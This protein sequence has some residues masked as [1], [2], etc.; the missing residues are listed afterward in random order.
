MLDL[1]ITDPCEYPKHM[2]DMMGRTFAFRVNWQAEWKQCSVLACL[3]SK[4]MVDT[5]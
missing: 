5:L 3:D 1:G 2:D 4:L